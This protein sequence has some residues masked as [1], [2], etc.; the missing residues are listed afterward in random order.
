MQSLFRDYLRVTAP[1]YSFTG[2][3]EDKEAVFDE[4]MAAIRAYKDA[5]KAPSQALIDA[6]WTSTGDIHTGTSAPA[7]PSEEFSEGACGSGGNSVFLLTGIT[8]RRVEYLFGRPMKKE[9]R[10]VE[11]TA[12][13]PAGTYFTNFAGYQ[14]SGTYCNYTRHIPQVMLQPFVDA[15]WKVTGTTLSDWTAKCLDILNSASGLSESCTDQFGVTKT[16]STVGVLEGDNRLRVYENPGNKWVGNLSAGYSIRTNPVAGQWHLESRY[17]EDDRSLSPCAVASYFRD[18]VKRNEEP[19]TDNPDDTYTWVLSKFT[20]HATRGTKIV[21]IVSECSDTTVTAPDIFDPTLIPQ[22]L[23][24]G[25]T[26]EGEYHPAVEFS[27]T[28]PGSVVVVGDGSPL[29]GYNNI[30]GALVFD[31]LLKKW[32]KMNVE[33]TNLV[34]FT[35]ANTANNPIVDYTNTGM[36]AGTLHSDGKIYLF[37]HKPADSFIRYGKVGYY[38]LGMVHFLETRIDF[39]DYATGSIRLDFSMDGRNIDPSLSHIR[40]YQDAL[41]YRV[42]PNQRSRWSTLTISGNYDLQYMEVRGNISGKR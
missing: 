41:S 15:L 17:V 13:Q 7:L 4:Y 9:F 29:L 11:D 18:A 23:P 42:Y 36:F 1:G 6:G 38:R 24:E 28:T 27:F 35:G 33:Y 26:I 34:D 40:Y 19:P 21:T 8:T 22:D 14:G 30:K 31:R 25:Y 37:D 16:W 2:F 39:R 5:S 32:G 20:P 12:S 3:S 10:W